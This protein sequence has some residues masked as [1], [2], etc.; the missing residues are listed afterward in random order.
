MNDYF[1]DRQV[2]SMQ[3]INAT[4]ITFSELVA[5]NNTAG[6]VGIDACGDTDIWL[7]VSE[8]QETCEQAV[9]K[10]IHTKETYK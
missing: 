4:Y 2:L 8:N 1:F 3:F 10:G 9:R 5:T 6:T 7:T